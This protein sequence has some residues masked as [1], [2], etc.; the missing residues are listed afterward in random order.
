MNIHKNDTVQVLSGK[1]RGKTGKVLNVDFKNERVLVE[2]INVYKKRS[3][4][5]R[6]G[7]KGEIVTL[8]RP[9]HYSK[10]L[11]YCSNCKKGVRVGFRL[12]GSNK[13]TR[14]CKKC[15]ISV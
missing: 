6:Q 10:V 8:P 15:Q 5:K 7:E 11:I 3:R 13:K 4:P 9:V 1:D 12:E 14:Y 2:N